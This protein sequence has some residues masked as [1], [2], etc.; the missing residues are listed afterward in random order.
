MSEN[1]LHG[2]LINLA[3]KLE[4]FALRL[5]QKTEDAKDLVQETSLRVLLNRDKYI[6]DENFKAWA[7]TIMKNIFINE[8]RSSL[9]KQTC[10]DPVKDFIFNRESGNSNPNSPDSEYSAK[11]ITQNI[12]QLDNKLRDPFKMHFQG[13]K[14]KEI[15]K[16][17]NLNIGTVKSRI[18]I[19]RKQL[20][21]KIKR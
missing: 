14:Y 1:E 7:F 9:R 5:T 2:Q 18:F 10:L 8:Y 17:L 16:E 15:A 6:N 13:F 4:R 21:Q 3:S 11:E 20:M 19:S 12:E